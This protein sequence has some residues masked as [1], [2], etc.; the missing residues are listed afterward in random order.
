MS[1][2]PKEAYWGV[3]P[4]EILF[5]TDIPS[6]AKMLYALISALTTKN[7][8]CW[9]TNDYITEFFGF[10]ERTIQRL[11]KSLEQGGYIRVEIGQNKHRAI[12]AGLNP[13]AG[14]NPDK[15]VGVT[16]TKMTGYPDKNDGINKDDKDNIYIPPYNPPTGGREP[17]YLPNHLPERFQKFWDF[18]RPHDRR[19]SRLRAIKS[20]DRLKPD[21]RMLKDM[22]R[23][24]LFLMA[25]EE[26]ER[27]IGIPHV[28]TFLNNRYWEDALENAAEDNGPGGW[29]PDPEVMHHD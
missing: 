29:A 11:L 14:R 5:N 25:G 16:P 6:S 15:N 20:W 17:K 26:W 19:G 4:G 13:L 1:E 9:A 3:I 23:G 28:A 18:Y 24:L 21:D 27:G 7:E 2:L 8:Y 10:S 22:A 12:Y